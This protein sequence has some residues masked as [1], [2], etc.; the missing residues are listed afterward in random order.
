LRF[1][2]EGGP[3]SHDSRGAAFVHRSECILD[4]NPLVE[5][6]VGIID[7]AATR[8]GEIAAEQGLQHENEGITLA[9]GKLLPDDIGADLRDLSEP[10][11]QATLP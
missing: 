3:W 6:R 10:N 5:D 1:D 9:A 7:L 4:R 11:S 8:A 2:E